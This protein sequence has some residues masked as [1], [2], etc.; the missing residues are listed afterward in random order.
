MADRAARLAFMLLPG[1]DHFAHDLVAALPVP[2]ALA[3]RAFTLRGLAD[4][5][6]ACAWADDPATD[7]IWFEFCWPPFPALIAQYDFAGRRVILRVHRIEAYETPHAA[8]APWHKIDDV[9]VVSTDMA[10]RLLTQAP[11]LQQ[12]TALHV[13]HNGV[14]VK[15]FVPGAPE[16]YRIGWCGL[17]NMRKNPLM[18]LEILH[19]LRQDDPRWHMH[20]CAKGGDP[21]ALDSFNLLLRRLDLTEAITVDGNVPAADMPAWHA[22]NSV[23]LSTSLH[24]SFGYAIA[25]AAC[26]GCDVA[27][28]DHMGAA[29]F[30]PD[31]T[32]FATAVEAAAM[33]KSS[34]PGKW[35]ETVVQRFSLR[36]QVEKLRRILRPVADDPEIPRISVGDEL[37]DYVVHGH[38][39]IR[40]DMR[41]RDEMEAAVFLL[42]SMG[43]RR[44]GKYSDGVLFQA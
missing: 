41:E 43:Y 19:L 1:L 15:R 8:G 20:L 26:C 14:D 38:S 35:R 18:A 5:N 30:W 32:R 28:L 25:E 31:E 22:R 11:R 3:V 12:S 4:L 24:E 13:V 27:L 21:V 40:L 44:A 37:L 16:P 29:E 6:A 36:M 10:A 7:A 2:G 17:L 39:A 33:I 9:I 42:E 34:R 23:L